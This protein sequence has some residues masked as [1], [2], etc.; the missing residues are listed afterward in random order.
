MLTYHGLL[1]TWSHMYSHIDFFHVTRKYNVIIRFRH[2]GRQWKWLCSMQTICAVVDCHNRHCKD[3]LISFYCFPTDADRHR[4]WISFVSR[5]NGDG[6]AWKLGDGDR[7][8][9]EHFVSKKKSDLPNSPDYV[10]SVY[11][12][13]IAK[14]LSRTASVSS[15]AHFERAKQCSATHEIEQLAKEKEEERNFIFV[16]RALRGFKNDRGAYCKVSTEQP[17]EAVKQV[18]ICQPGRLSSSGVEDGGAIT[19]YSS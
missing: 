4:K 14:K 11:H 19:V 15:L 3:N 16:Q 5:Q 18:V 12:E 13:T 6:T 10:P 9:S 7:V 1:H 2:F 17:F 8:C